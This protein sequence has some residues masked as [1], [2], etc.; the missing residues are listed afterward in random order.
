M[1]FTVTVRRLIS[2]SIKCT[3]ACKTLTADDGVGPV[4]LTEERVELDHLL[5][6]ALGH[7]P[8]FLKHLFDLLSE[9]LTQFGMSSECV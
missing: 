3:S 7:A 6:G 4:N 5:K 2:L 8:F 9:G 1:R